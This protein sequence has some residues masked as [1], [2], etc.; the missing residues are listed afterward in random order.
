[1]ACSFGLACLGVDA[2]LINHAAEGVE[3]VVYGLLL[4]WG[5]VWFL[6]G[7]GRKIYLARWSAAE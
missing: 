4:A 6:W 7:V 5:G 1:M 2:T 3:M